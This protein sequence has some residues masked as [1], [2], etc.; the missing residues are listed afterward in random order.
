MAREWQLL[1]MLKRAGRGH[2]PTG[3]L[4]TKRGECAVLCPACP[5]PGKN[6]PDNWDGLPEKEQYVLQNIS[7]YLD[8]MSC[9]WLYALFLALDANFRLRH[10]KVS[11]HEFDPGL[12]D[13]FAY[14]LWETLYKHFLGQY[15]GADQEVSLDWTPYYAILTLHLQRSTCTSHSAVNSVDK[16][17]ARGV[18][19][20]GVVAVD[21]AR[22]SFKRPC[23]VGDL[24]KGE[25]F[26]YPLTHPCHSLKLLQIPEHRLRLF[27]EPGRHKPHPLCRLLRYCLPM[28]EK[29]LGTHV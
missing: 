27:L 23:S 28:V 9:R 5:H 22:H 15:G 12:S 16:R 7:F 24:Q 14:F 17:D 11:S 29:S 26:V 2:D 10:S 25:R 8:F 1:K 21:C 13:G 3:H 18:D 19:A 4:G 6:L 20:T